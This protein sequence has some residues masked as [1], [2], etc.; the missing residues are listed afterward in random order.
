MG[1]GTSGPMQTMLADAR[2]RPPADP[3]SMHTPPGRRHAVDVMGCLHWDQRDH[4]MACK[5]STYCLS[6]VKPAAVC[7]V[8]TSEYACTHDII[9]CHEAADIIN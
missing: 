1:T 4:R 3:A 2:L 9:Q 8:P 6:Y 7:I 5:L